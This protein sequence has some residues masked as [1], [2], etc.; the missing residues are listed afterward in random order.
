MVDLPIPSA[1]FVEAQNVQNRVSA[2]DYARSADYLG[3]GIDKLSAGLDNLAVP[4]AEQAG[5]DAAAKAVTRNA[6]G[7]VSVDNSGSSFILG[8]AGEAYAHAVTLGKLA[9]GQTETSTAMNNLRQEHMGDPEGFQTAA[10]AYADSLKAKFGNNPLGAS[11]VE[12][13]NSIAAQHYNGLVNQKASLDVNK[14]LEAVNTQITDQKN[15]LQALA[16][17]GGTETDEFK[18]ASANLNGLYDQLGA[19]SL[20][21]ISQK[22][23]DSEKA[24]AISEMR[25]EAVVGQVDRDFNKKGKA[26]AQQELTDNIMNNPSLN[27][28]DPERKQLYSWGMS[29]LQYLSGE[30]QARVDANKETVNSLVSSAHS[31]INVPDEM[32]DAAM[33]HTQDLGDDEGWSKMDAA[34]TATQWGRG[35]TGLSP[36]QSLDSQGVGKGA[37]APAASGPATPDSIANAK[38]PA[39]AIPPSPN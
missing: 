19:N 34:R 14:S 10:G 12:N 29:R 30:Q 35:G 16:R 39:S 20:F 18:K 15:T 26:G 3:S 38:P 33:D 11:M 37:S 23:I 9:A 36:Q 28:S 22:K 32:W 31:G 5:R 17:Q 27:L 21:G 6:D 2:D 7:S 1:P 4:L 24:R 8:R 25:G 13:A